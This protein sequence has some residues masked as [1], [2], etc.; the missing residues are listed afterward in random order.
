[1]NT[2]VVPA[3]PDTTPP[4]APV[5]LPASPAGSTPDQPELDGLHR[6]CRRHRL[7]G[8]ALPGHGL[9]QLRQVAQ[10]AGTSLNDTG[11]VGVDHLPLPG[12]R[13]RPGRQPSAYSVIAAATTA[14]RRHHPAVGAHRAGGHRGEHQPDRS[15]LERL[16]RQRRRDRVPGRALPGHDLHQLRADRDA[17]HDELQQ[18]RTCRRHQLPLPRASRR[19]RR[20]PERLLRH[21]HHGNPARHLGAERAVGLDGIAGRQQPDQPQLDGL[22]RRRRRDRLPGRALPGR[23]LH[24]LRPDRPPTAPPT[25]TPASRRPPPTAT[26]SAPQTRP[27][28]SVRTSADCGA[29]PTLPA[30]CGP[31]RRLGV[32]RGDSRRRR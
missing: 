13:R 4:S 29:P 7:P 8:R 25:T 24:Q 5:G 31:G 32:R 10:P 16:D 22:H 18:H 23:G 9:H 12:P 19:R 17:D 1:M 26:R 15:E 14:R 11:L 20:Q 28:T 3:A 2:A 21:R 27:A 30:R 6:R